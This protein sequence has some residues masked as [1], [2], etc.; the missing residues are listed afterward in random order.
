VSCGESQA[1][2]SGY[3][4]YFHTKKSFKKAIQSFQGKPVGSPFSL[5]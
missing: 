4:L 2:K 3:S 1:Q 5:D